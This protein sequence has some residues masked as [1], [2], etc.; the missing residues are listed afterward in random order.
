MHRRTRSGSSHAQAHCRARP[1]PSRKHW[2]GPGRGWWSCDFVVLDQADDVVG[3][4]FRAWAVLD[5]NA[6]DAGCTWR[7]SWLD[8]R[9]VLDRFSATFVEGAAM[10]E[11][12]AGCRDG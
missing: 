8:L 5:T 12:A 10:F 4:E 11:G 3:D 1:R 7:A 6:I 2:R 9:A